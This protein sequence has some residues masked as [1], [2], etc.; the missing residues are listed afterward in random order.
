MKIKKAKLYRGDQKS[1]EL[2]QWSL[3]PWK[4]QGVLSIYP[5]IQGIVSWRHVFMSAIHILLTLC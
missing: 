4:I 2:S 5:G 3:K 1:M